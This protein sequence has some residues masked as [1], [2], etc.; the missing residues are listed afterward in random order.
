MGV[1]VGVDIELLPTNKGGLSAPV[2]LTDDID[3]RFRPYFKVQDGDGRSIPVEFFDA[4]VDD[5]E[6]G[7]KTNGTVSYL[8]RN[9]EVNSSLKLEDRFDIIVDDRIVGTGSV[10]GEYGL[11]VDWEETLEWQK[12]NADERRKGT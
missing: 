8:D 9:D 10:T 2:H 11:D 12:R 6:P 7:E 1:Y 4:L 3:R 5:L